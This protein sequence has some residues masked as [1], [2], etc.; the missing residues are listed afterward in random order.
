MITLYMPK[1]RINRK[2]YKEVIDANENLLY[3]FRM[4]IF[5]TKFELL[6]QND[7]LLFYAKKASIFRS[8]Y[9]IYKSETMI[10]SLVTKSFF[11][12]WEYYIKSNKD[13]LFVEGSIFGRRFSIREENQIVLT[14]TKDPHKKYVRIITVD[15]SQKDYLIMVMLSLIAARELAGSSD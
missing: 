7:K 14:I 2:N 12:Q 13:N 3:Q 1:K 10:T 8:H 9:D 11:K 5:C 6:S 15:E 4:N